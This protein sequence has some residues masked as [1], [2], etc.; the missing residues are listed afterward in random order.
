MKIKRTLSGQIDERTEGENS[1]FFSLEIAFG[2]EQHWKQM[3]RHRKLKTKKKEVHK[4]CS[5][6][7]SVF[8]A[9]DIVLLTVGGKKS[10]NTCLHYILD[11][12]PNVSSG[13]TVCGPHETRNHIF[14]SIMSGKQFYNEEKQHLRNEH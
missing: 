7:W 14:G 1:L 8:P 3:H 13:N 12:V 6:S 9:G 10:I 11:L 2:Y 5:A 4:P